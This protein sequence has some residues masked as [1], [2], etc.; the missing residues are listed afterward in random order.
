VA[1][2]LASRLHGAEVQANVELRELGGQLMLDIASGDQ[3]LDEKEQVVLEELAKLVEQGPTASEL[4]VAVEVYLKHPSRATSSPATLA[5]LLGM[6]ELFMGD[7][8]HY[9]KLSEAARR[10]T[11]Q[12][13]QAAAR[14][15]MA[16][17]AIVIHF[18][19]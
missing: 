4:G 9:Q 13:V 5:L 12:N 10:A 16:N 15:W 6:G 2:R 1:N 14:K 3:P 19:P 11:P 17:R 18:I 8:E 7:P